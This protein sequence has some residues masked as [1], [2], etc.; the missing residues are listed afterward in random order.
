MA[1]KFYFMG[2]HGIGGNTTQRCFV[3]ALSDKGHK[4]W[5]KTPLP[6]IYA[7]IPN[8]N[9]VHANTPLR[10]QKKSEQASKIIFSEPEKNLKPQKIFY[11]VKRL[12][13]GSI[14]RSA[15]E[16]TVEFKKKTANHL[17]KQIAGFHLADK[18]AHT[19][20]DDLFDCYTYGLIIAFGN[21]DAL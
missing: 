15:H 8:V 19:R 11:G 2:M 13:Q 14:T 7:G 20:A 21:Y 5:L 3:R 18:K 16:K 12:A 1:K 17:W 4:V 6:E 9:F 10:T